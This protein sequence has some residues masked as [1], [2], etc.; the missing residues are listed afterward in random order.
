MLSPKEVAQYHETG[1]VTPVRRLGEDVMA[2]IKEKMEALFEARPNLDQDYAPNL[3]EMDR[4][5]LDYAAYPDVLD[6]AAELIGDNIIVTGSSFFCK[7]GIGGKATPWHQDA[8]YW[9]M[10]PLE[11]CTV[12]IAIDPSTPENG[13]LR[14]IPESHKERGLFSHLSSTSDE[15]VGLEKE[16][17][18][19]DMPDTEPVDVILE[20][21]MMSFHH[22]YVLHGAEPNNSGARRG[23][24]DLPL[25]AD[26]LVLRPGDRS[27]ARAP[28]SSVQCRP[29]ASP[30]PRHRRLRQERHLPAGGMTAC[31]YKRTF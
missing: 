31:G 23:G 11:A 14:V 5:W 19:E 15:N 1:Q 20:P 26:E 16:L 29:P 6:A 13:C 17:S 8:Y 21:G 24:A 25:Y 18:A 4:G 12:W 10:R 27:T 9:P 3:I 28:G 30:G 2:A 7:K 22:P